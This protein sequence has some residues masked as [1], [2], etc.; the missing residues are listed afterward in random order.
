MIRTLLIAVLASLP[1][2]ADPF[3]WLEDVGGEEAVAWAETQ[4]DI[5]I[6]ELASDSTFAALKERIRAVLDADDRIPFVA[7]RGRYYYNFWRDAANPRGLLRRTTLE[8]YAKPTPAWEAV[9][10][11]DA[12]ARREGENWVYKGASFL[13]P[14]YDRALVRLSRGGADATVIREFDLD[15][16]RFVVPGFDLPESKGGA[17]WF[18]RDTLIVGR[19][20]GAGSLTESG[21]P[22]VVKQWR[23]GQ[24]LDAA[25]VLFEGE[26]TDVG[27][28][29]GVVWSAARSDLVVRRATDFF[30]ERRF[31]WRDGAFVHLPIPDDASVGIDRDWLIIELKSDWAIGTRSYER[32]A[33]MITSLD[34]FLAGERNFTVLHEP[35]ASTAVSGYTTTA[36]Y[37][38]VNV[39]D[40]V[41]NRI[42]VWHASG[43]GFT[44]HSRLGADGF[45][46]LS[47]NA[48]DR[49]KDDRFFLQTT[50][51]I[52]PPTLEMRA[53]GV[54]E[55]LVVKQATH[56]FGTDGVA[57]EQHWATSKDG[58]RVPYFQIGRAADTTRPTLLYGY[59]GFEISLLPNYSGS[60]GAAWIERGG[61]YVV[62]NIRGGGEFGPAWHQAALKENRPR[63]YE[64]FIAVAE[65]LIARG[66][67]T[68][69]QL[70][71][72]GG[73]NGGLLTGNMLT[74]RPNLFGAIVSAVP[75]LDM[76][77]YSHLL[78]GASW[79]AEYGDPDDPEQWRFMR[80]FSPYHNVAA[81]ADYPPVLVTTSTRDDRVHPGHA[82]KMVAKMKQMEHEVTYF[83]N[84]EG[85]HA[86]AA[87]NEQ[88]AF[89]SALSYA[90]LWKHLTAP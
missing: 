39:L 21:Y 29:G 47:V 88:R 53:I 83:E 67:T 25:E 70:G 3:Q 64:D 62:A 76:R 35:T 41:R 33:L 34:G 74:M 23:R 60:V 9:I 80:T 68:S 58:T 57:V 2:A 26:T 44:F 87:N 17:T 14:T 77:R 45:R 56:Q 19:D 65:D 28:F 7:K 63:A 13:P 36:R 24:S 30:H 55:P 54:A 1:A 8:E 37:V 18:D 32:G 4:S 42:D 16:L 84:T 59:G 90:F 71:T 48:V 40:N 50:D 86:G 46:T 73:S 43:D 82:R 81:G 11:V 31:I 52:T 27:T 15:A 75:L 79:M 51:F 12:L 49:H 10:D 89:M 69:S 66:V 5:A 38:F 85:G 61:V 20:F 78:A 6:A 72:R 22:R